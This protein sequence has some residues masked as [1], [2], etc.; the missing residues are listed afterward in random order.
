MSERER[1]DRITGR[2]ITVED[3]RALAG[4]ATPH[5]ALQIRNR[6]Q[7]LIEPLPPGDAARVEG[8]RQIARLT[9][10]AMHSGDPR[11]PGPA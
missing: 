11:G 4:P 6:I 1:E 7:R 5:F 3:M 10:L 2:E 9:D 8:E